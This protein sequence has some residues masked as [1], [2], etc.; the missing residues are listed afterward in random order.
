[1][2]VF[3]AAERVDQH[4]V[5]GHVREHA[6]LD[7]RVV[8]GDQH[9]ARLGDERT[10]D[11][12]ADLG[13]DRDVLQVGIAAAEATGCRDGLIEA[14]VDAPGLRV[15]EL[16][17]GVDIRALQLHQAAPFENDARQLVRQRELLEHFERR[18]LCLGL[19]RP[20]NRLGPHPHLVE[21][22]LRQ[23][24]RGIDVE[25]L[26]G[27]LVDPRRQAIEVGFDPRGL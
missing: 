16:R 25:L 19:R 12:A 3:A 21:E 5:A 1:V 26:A 6:Q 27:Q 23:L 4:L 7:L 10:P 20:A 8:G 17:Q 18:R 9:V 22:H 2:D 11:L 14:G 15:D 24:L 13:A